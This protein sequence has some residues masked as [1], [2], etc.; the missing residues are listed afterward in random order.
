M[1]PTTDYFAADAF[2][3]S[4]LGALVEKVPFSP[5]LIQE[6][7]WFDEA[8]IFG[9]RVDIES[10]DG[11]LTVLP[12]SARCGP[13]TITDQADRKLNDLRCPHI[14]EKGHPITADD[15]SNV[16]RVGGVTETD[17]LTL[18]GQ[19]L[20]GIRANI[21]HTIDRHRLYALMGVI[22][23]DPGDVTGSKSLYTEFGTAEDSVDFIFATDAD[24][25]DKFMSVY[26]KMNAALG[27][28]TPTEI[29][30]L[31]ENT[32]FD[33]LLAVAKFKALYESQQTLWGVQ[34]VDFTRPRFP[35]LLLPPNIRL[36]RY[37][38]AAATGMTAKTCRF[39][40]AGAGVLKTFWGASDIPAAASNLGQRI[41][42][43]RPR[44]SVDGKSWSVAG[45]S[46]GL[47][48]CTRPRALIKGHSST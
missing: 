24:K 48:I 26:D 17:L 23:Y 44:E 18:V 7:G 42:V 27:S 6:S 33:I 28:V 13:E 4:N 35:Q 40:P 2:G 39:F 10:L 20:A 38:T 9:T 5:R 47:H 12:V 30:G 11:V 32:F 8:P 45:Q 41:F 43:D 25:A 14:G 29:V 21:E 1:A 15:I 36:I 46:N 31:C 34:P 22:A 3:M 37:G 16:R 19:R